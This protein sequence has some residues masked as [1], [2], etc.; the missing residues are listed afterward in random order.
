MDA[1]LLCVEEW[2]DVWMRRGKNVWLL[3]GWREAYIN[4]GVDVANK[5][6]D[7]CMRGQMSVLRD[8]WMYRGI[9]GWMK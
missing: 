2:I 1:W 8:G 5:Q 4:R 9:H 7:Y 6:V 3:G